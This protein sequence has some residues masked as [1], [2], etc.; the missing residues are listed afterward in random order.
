[1]LACRKKI[2]KSV[3]LRVLET[4]LF[5]CITMSVCFFLAEY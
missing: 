2:K 5:S 4:I 1:M 3:P